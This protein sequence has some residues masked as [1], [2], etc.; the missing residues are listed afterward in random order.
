M[1][2]RSTQAAA[3]GAQ[4]AAGGKVMVSKGGVN[5]GGAVWRRDGRE[6]FYLA[7]GRYS[8]VGRGQQPNRRSGPRGPPQALFQ[9]AP[10]VAYFDVSADGERFLISVPDR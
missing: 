2:G 6:L 4:L 8:D 7:A 1:C 5:R 3:P 10:E 9:I